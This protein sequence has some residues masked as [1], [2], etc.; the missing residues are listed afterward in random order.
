MRRV[1][2]AFLVSCCACSATQATSQPT[3]SPEP[4][5]SPTAAPVIEPAQPP[6]RPPAFV[7]PNARL[8]PGAVATT[9]TSLVCHRSTATI[10][11]PVSYT[12]ALT[13][14]QI[15]QYGYTDRFLSDYEEDHL[16]ALELGGAPR[17]PRNLWPEPRYTFPGAAQKD[18][19][20][21]YLHRAVCYGTMPL[22]TAQHD[23]ATDWFAVW[24]RIGRPS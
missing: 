16:I 9:D 14:A 1:L 5:A 23:I 11:P 20:E 15:A 7:L 4:T 13:R 22:T 18:T 8:T 24:V 3:A 12:Q 6:E 17:D 10:R 19:V 2:L 21:N